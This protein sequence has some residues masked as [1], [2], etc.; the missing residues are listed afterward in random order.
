MQSSSRRD[1]RARVQPFRRFVAGALGAAALAA[2]GLAADGARADT[3]ACEEVERYRLPNGVDVV[4]QVDRSL[5][6][7][8]VVS[9]VEAGLRYEPPGYEGLAHY[10][11]HLLYRGGGDFA[12]A[13]PLYYEAGAQTNASTT[14]DTVDYHALLPSTELE[15]AIWLEARRLGVGLDALDE[16]AAK[17]E[18]QVLLREEAVRRDSERWRNLIRA[19]L[20]AVFGVEHPY[21]R[22]AATPESIEPLTLSDARW[23]FAE[24]YKPHR[25]RLAVV[26]DVDPAR[27][28]ALVERHF[29][30]LEHRAPVTR[31]GVAQSVKHDAADCEL[32]KQPLAPSHRRIVQRAPRLLEQLQVIWPIPPGE[33]AES[34]RPAL[35]LVAAYV[36]EAAQALS[37]FNQVGV[38]LLSYQLGGF[39]SLR[40]TAAP[41]LEL[42][43]LE[44]LV[45]STI[46]EVSNRRMT[47]PE[48]QQLIRR[49]ELEQRA[50]R[51]S[52]LDRA[53]KLARRTCSDLPCNPALPQ[54]T[55]ITTWFARDKALVI[56]ERDSTLAPLEGNL[57]VLP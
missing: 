21:A 32:A 31:P 45:W 54:P 50:S 18:V 56:E 14:P 7:V 52:F 53:L 34:L 38:E 22:L 40:I 3:L 12:T 44:E 17:N 55:T 11:E 57:E 42:E 26:G 43:A 13:L 24:H 30:A 49:S 9:S 15:R 47:G 19:Q 41:D 35:A 36:R 23:F 6:L 46:A 39:W 2:V 28:R 29:G 33:H 5:P 27:T 4:V 25:T 51:P 10:V 37:T 16:V 48:R 8:A 1:V 20:Q